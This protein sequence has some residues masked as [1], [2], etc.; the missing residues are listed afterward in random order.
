MD[1]PLRLVLPVGG[2]PEATGWY[3]RANGGVQF[4][5][6]ALQDPA[7]VAAAAVHVSNLADG[8]CACNGPAGRPAP[9]RAEAEAP[10]GEDD[11]GLHPSS[12]VAPFHSRWPSVAA[13]LMIHQS[14]TTP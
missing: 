14:S 4:V 1:P 8:Q 11:R 7:K 12:V 6:G 10:A 9:P 3:A 13:Q 2:M 5:L